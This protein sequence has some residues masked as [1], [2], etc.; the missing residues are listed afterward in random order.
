[1]SEMTSLPVVCSSKTPVLKLTIARKLEGEQKKNERRGSGR[2][3][4]LFLFSPSPFIPLF[5]SCPN[6][7]DELPR[8]RLLSRLA[9]P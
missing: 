2:K 8:K 5:S 3:E 1:M 7:F 9:I 4:A 6:F